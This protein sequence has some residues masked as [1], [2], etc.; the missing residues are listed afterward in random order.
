MD[1]EISKLE[2]YFEYD[3]FIKCVMNEI[4]L[5]TKIDFLNIKSKF[6]Q[7]NAN[8]VL[9]SWIQEIETILNQNP[10]I[11]NL[12]LQ[13][14]QGFET[15]GIW[16]TKNHN[17]I[18]ILTKSCRQITDQAFLKLFRNTLIKLIDI[19]YIYL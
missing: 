14:N 9:K 5:D 16:I 7:E 13:G 12:H 1:Y 11:K 10:K 8:Q 17:A 3:I 4:G 19:E 18:A 2:D 15:F 6:G